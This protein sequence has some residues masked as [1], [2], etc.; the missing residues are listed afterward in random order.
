[1]AVKL[2]KCLLFLDIRQIDAQALALVP[3]LKFNE[4][5][6]FVALYY[7]LASDVL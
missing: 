5:V 4:N 6:F 3:N 2:L 1:M 7:Y